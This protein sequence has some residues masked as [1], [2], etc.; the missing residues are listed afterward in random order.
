M[1]GIFT[2]ANKNRSQTTLKE[3]ELSKGF[4][5]LDLGCG[6]GCT[7]LDVFKACPDCFTIGVD[8]SKTIA[9]VAQRNVAHGSGQNINIT[10]SDWSA[11]PFV[12]QKFDRAVAS[13][14]IYFWENTD[15]VLTEIH[16]VLKPSGR[17]TILF[18]P[19]SHDSQDKFARYGYRTYSQEEV[20]EALQKNGFRVSGMKKRTEQNKNDSWDV[21]WLTAT[22][23]PR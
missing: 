15:N 13:N 17:L 2:L 5:V 19:I 12:S 7:L 8:R 9:T 1:S 10:L 21:L 6:N 23:R 18:Q 16:R 11:L 3:L 14:V 22:S 20:S 4:Y